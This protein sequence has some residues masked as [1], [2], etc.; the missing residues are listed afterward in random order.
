MFEVMNANSN[1]RNLRCDHGTMR[2]E[3]DFS[4][5]VRG[6]HAARY[7]SGTNVVVLDPDVAAEFRTA[8]EV[9]DALRALALSCAS[10]R[11]ALIARQHSESSLFRSATPHQIFHFPLDKP[12]KSLHNRNLPNVRKGRCDG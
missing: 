1:K 8:Q 4:K 5:G 3:Y 6:K 12:L 2:S 7:A 9:N 11:S 10:A